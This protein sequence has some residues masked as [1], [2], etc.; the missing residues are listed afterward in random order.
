MSQEKHMGDLHEVALRAGVFQVVE[1]EAKAA[2]DTARNQ[3]MAMLPVGDAVAGRVG[4]DILCKASWSKGSQKVTVTDPTAYLAWVKECHPTE[5]VESVNTAYTSSLKAVEGVVIDADGLP[6]DGVEFISGNPSLSIR[7]EKAALALV[8]QL[9]ADVDEHLAEMGLRLS[10]LVGVEQ[11]EAW[12]GRTLSDDDVE[13]LEEAIPNSSIPEAV[14]AI[15][16][17]W[18]DE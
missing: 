17:S 4:D 7:S 9:V 8:Q 1:R 16:S 5:V 18:G 11:A 13:R 14:D 3:L 10:D 15:V 12:C 2:K 6:V